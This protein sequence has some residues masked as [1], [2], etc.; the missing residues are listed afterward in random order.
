MIVQIAGMA[1]TA[2]GHGSDR[3]HWQLFGWVHGREFDGIDYEFLM[4][5]IA[6]YVASY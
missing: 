3:S 1:R 4:E 5:S 2:T 6:L